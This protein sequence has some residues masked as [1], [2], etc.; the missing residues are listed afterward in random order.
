MGKNQPTDK[1]QT[2]L[3]SW[4]PGLQDRLWEKLPGAT[5]KPK[6]GSEKVCDFYPP[7]L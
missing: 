6:N 5:I 7:I 4:E 2:N 3:E 1:F